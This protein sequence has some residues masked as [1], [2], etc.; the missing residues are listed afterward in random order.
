MKTLS[1]TE[2]P[3]VAHSTR[4]VNSGQAENT[5]SENLFII[6]PNIPL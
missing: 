2:S 5:E 6:K 1:L 4:S 3:A